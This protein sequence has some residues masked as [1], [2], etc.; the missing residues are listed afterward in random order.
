MTAVANSGRRPVVESG[1]DRPPDG[2]V[3]HTEPLLL[4]RDPS[5]ASRSGANAH[6][7]ELLKSIHVL[8]E[9][10]WK[11]AVVDDAV[12]VGIAIRRSA[13]PLA[14]KASP[15][16]VVMTC[17]LMHAWRGSAGAD[18]VLR[19]LRRRLLPMQRSED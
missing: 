7:V 9:P 16:D 1:D 4:W 15:L 12:A 17:L 18:M 19:N 14:E 2:V 11:E 5:P 8:G 13:G 3:L 6:I 10:D